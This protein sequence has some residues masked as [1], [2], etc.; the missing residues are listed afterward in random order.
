MKEN[1]NKKQQRKTMKNN[2]KQKNMKMMKDK[3]GNNET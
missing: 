2:E 3:E 1:K